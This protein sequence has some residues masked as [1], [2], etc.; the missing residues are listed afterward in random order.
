MKKQWETEKK[1]LLGEKAVLQDA[2]KRLNLQIR[3]AKEEV[4]TERAR[5]GSQSVSCWTV[6]LS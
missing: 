6:R 3:T 4:K 5:S 1:Q 2:A